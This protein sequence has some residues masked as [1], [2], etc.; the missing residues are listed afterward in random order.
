MKSRL[1]H[2]FKK[3]S[4]SKNNSCE[5]KKKEKQAA[6]SIAS[7]YTPTDERIIKIKLPNGTKIRVSPSRPTSRLLAA[8]TPTSSPD[9]RPQILSRSPD[10]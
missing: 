9:L 6:L 1:Q 7:A 3:C 8:T 5:R 2:D 10:T 4:F